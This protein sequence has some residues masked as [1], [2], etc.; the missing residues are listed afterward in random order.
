MRENMLS[1]NK[2]WVEKEGQSW[3]PG[4]ATSVNDIRGTGFTANIFY[5]LGAV[6]P[7]RTLITKTCDSVQKMYR[8][9][10]FRRIVETMQG[11][12]RRKPQAR[13]NARP[14]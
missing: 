9:L 2:V 3:M 1:K 7:T 12:S 14:T 13:S 10:L 11:I 8:K 5:I 6:Y 4:P